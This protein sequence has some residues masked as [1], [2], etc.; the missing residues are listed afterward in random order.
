MNHLLVRL[1]SF[2]LTFIAIILLFIVF[3]SPLFNKYL[4]RKLKFFNNIYS[5]QFENSEIH[6]YICYFSLFVLQSFHMSIFD[7]LLFR[8]CVCVYT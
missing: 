4:I 7:Q 6:D 1:C 2:G 5:K 3:W 8:M